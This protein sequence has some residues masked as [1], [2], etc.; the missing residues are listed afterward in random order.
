MFPLKGGPRKIEMG[1]GM[2]KVRGEEVVGLM[3]EIDRNNNTGFIQKG[4]FVLAETAS[5]MMEG[6][7]FAFHRQGI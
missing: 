6:S 5:Q 7:H 2:G 1:K 4:N 3:G